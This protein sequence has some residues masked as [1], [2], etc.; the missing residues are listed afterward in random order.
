MRGISTYKHIIG[1]RKCIG[2]GCE[3]SIIMNNLEQNKI[4]IHEQSGFRSTH[5]C[6]TS[7]ILTLSMQTTSSS[8]KSDDR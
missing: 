3:N 2:F 6:V 7:L 4:L 5:S 1:V 8:V